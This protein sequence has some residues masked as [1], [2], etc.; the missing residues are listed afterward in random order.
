MATTGCH[1]IAG[2][3]RIC[4]AYRR[5]TSLSAAPSRFRSR[6]E[7]VCFA[8]TK[9]KGRHLVE[10]TALLIARFCKV[11]EWRDFR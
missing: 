10:V 5:S 1:A 9:Q 4:L 7:I 6:V 3:G 11:R 2:L 8:S